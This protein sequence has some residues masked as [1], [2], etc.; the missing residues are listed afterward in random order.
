MFAVQSPEAALMILMTGRSLRLDSATAMRGIHVVK[1]KPTLS[2]ALIEGLVLASGKCEYF[3]LIE[4]TSERA[5]YETKRIGAPKE[6]RMSWSREDS[7]LAGLMKPSA[8]GE[9]SNHVRRPRTMFRWRCVAELARAVYPDVTMG[10]YLPE[11]LEE[12]DG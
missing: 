5:V 9:P 4:S 8:S 11:E 10:L 12:S 3:Q 2:A 6:V 1:G 7:E